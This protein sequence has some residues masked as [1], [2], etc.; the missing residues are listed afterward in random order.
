MLFIIELYTAVYQCRTYCKCLGL[1]AMMA[2]GKV[3][4]GMVRFTDHSTTHITMSLL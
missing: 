2:R 1:E 4:V 3:D